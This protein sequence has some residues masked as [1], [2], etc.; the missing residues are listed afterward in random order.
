VIANLVLFGASGD[1]AGRDL[2]PA[3]ASLHASGRLPERITIVGTARPDRTT[4]ASAAT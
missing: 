1:L 3:L 2:F 4:R